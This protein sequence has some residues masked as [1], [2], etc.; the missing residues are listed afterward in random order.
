[1]NEQ[2]RSTWQPPIVNVCASRQSDE[3]TASTLA[4][5]LQLHIVPSA[6]RPP[7]ARP[8]NQHN[9]ISVADSQAWV[10][11]VDGTALSLLR[12]DGARLRVDFTSGKTAHRSRESGLRKVP[13][14]KAVGIDR[15]Y[16]RFARLPSVI[17]TTAG[18]GQDGW[19]LANLGCRITLL[20][21]SALLHC[22]LEQALILAA[23]KPQTMAIASKIELHY[24]EAARWLLHRNFPVADVV[25][26]DPMFPTRL[27]HARV[28]K[29]MQFLHELVGP[30]Q[31]ADV[32]LSAAITAASFRVVVK[33]PRGAA[34]LD[35]D[36]LWSG[37]VTCIAS[38]TM[39]YDVYHINHENSET[40]MADQAPLP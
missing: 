33:R 4:A 18:L 11:Q 30:A 7:A 8:T 17:D 20:E 24:T 37:Q 28:K 25:Y 1:M 38:P 6:A 9:S 36:N 13:L 19:L 40:V 12:P 39:R 29:A 14:A 26:L 15:F 23:A 31:D 27:K 2:R 35:A 21:N 16:K 3:A 34:R 22:M 10:L 32:L 5:Q